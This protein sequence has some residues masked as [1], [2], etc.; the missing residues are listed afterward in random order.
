MKEWERS[1]V[2]ME[3]QK[4]TDFLGYEM[5]HSWPETDLAVHDMYILPGL[6]AAKEEAELAGCTFEPQLI[7]E[8]LVSHGRALRMSQALHAVNS[9]TEWEEMEGLPLKPEQH[10]RYSQSKKGRRQRQPDQGHEVD[11]KAHQIRASRS[12][13]LRIALCG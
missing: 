10:H 7:S 13:L 4:V 1:K 11:S 6:Q 2:K 3:I 12:G 9:S 8:Q 5:L